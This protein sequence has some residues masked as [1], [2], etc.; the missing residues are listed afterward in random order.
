MNGKLVKNKS[1]G[2]ITFHL[3]PWLSVAAIGIHCLRFF[4][5]D[6]FCSAKAGSLSTLF[7][8]CSYRVFLQ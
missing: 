7:S 2:R 8:I 4:R 1:G 5:I 3:S 6:I